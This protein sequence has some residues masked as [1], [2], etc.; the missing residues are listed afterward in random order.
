MKTYE[1]ISRQIYLSLFWGWQAPV[2]GG[3]VTYNRLTRSR[4]RVWL[5]IMH[6]LATSRF[7]NLKSISTKLD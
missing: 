4:D 2:V 6:L 5:V 1:L 3:V 7:N